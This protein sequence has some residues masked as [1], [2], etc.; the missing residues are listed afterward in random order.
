MTNVFSGLRVTV[1]ALIS[2]ASAPGWAIEPA[3]IANQGTGNQAACAGCH[4]KD[5]GG[6]GS[7]P[8]LAGM[9]AS[10]LL[11]QLS[12]FASGS[13]DSAIMKPI[14]AVLSPDDRKAVAGY[15]AQLPI[16]KAG[17]PIES[18]S[19]ESIGKQLAMRGVWSKEV[20]ACVQC[21]GPGGVGVGSSF[22]ALAGQ[23]SSYITGQLQ[24]WQRGTRRNDPLELMRHIASKLSADEVSA[25]SEWFA[26]QPALPSAG[27]P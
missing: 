1:L 26:R 27:R 22:P 4:G 13:R 14:V 12:D 5:G 7:F 23:S 21:H 19:A 8:R 6:Q 10:Y 2:I 16:P 11:K 24:A 15:F 25:V 9:N 20:P 18:A 17:A 3:T